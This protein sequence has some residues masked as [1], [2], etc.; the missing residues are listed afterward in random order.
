M[1]YDP[2][3]AADAA[4]LLAR[5]GRMRSVAGRVAQSVEAIDMPG[6]FVDAERAVRA[7]T[8]ADRMLVRLPEPGQ[9]GVT[10]ARQRLRAFA[11]QILAIIEALPSPKTFRDVERAAR[12]V[13]ASDTLLVQLYSPPKAAK[14][15]RKDRFDIDACDEDTGDSPEADPAESDSDGVTGALFERLDH[16]AL[17]HAHQTGFYPDGTA[18]DPARAVE[19]HRL[20]CPEEMDILDQWISDT[21]GKPFVS[22]ERLLPLAQ[23]MT[24]RANAS[25]RAQARHLGQW[26]DG[27]AFRDNDPPAFVLS[28]RFDREILKRPGPDYSDI[29]EEPADDLFPWWLVRNPD[30]G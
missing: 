18:C 11:D 1:A 29:N 4:A 15:A 22:D 6:T 25:V 30:T 23:I 3:S 2:T 5:R 24:A 13:L 27:R 20:A 7:I 21:A 28:K 14:R 12:C 10:P 9:N 16:V 8:L 26:P 17:A 19:P